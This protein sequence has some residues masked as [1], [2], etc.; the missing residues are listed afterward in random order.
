MSTEDSYLLQ[1]VTAGCCG[2]SPLFWCEGGGGYTPWIAEAKVWTKEEAEQVIVSTSGSHKW[3]MWPLALIRSVSA[4]A[5]D[6]EDLRKYGDP[7]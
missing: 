4:A 1:N 3:K 2:N 5:V 7:T 6:I